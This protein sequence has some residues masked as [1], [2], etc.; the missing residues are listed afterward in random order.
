MIVIS[1]PYPIFQ[2]NRRDERLGESSDSPADANAMS[3]RVVVRLSE[4]IRQA[5]IKYGYPFR[6]SPYTGL[7]CVGQRTNGHKRRFRT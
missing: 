1:Q 5:C 2:A 6:V 3:D 7:V 4:A